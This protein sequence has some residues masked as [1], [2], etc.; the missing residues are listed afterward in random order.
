MSMVEP[1]G[2]FG[3]VYTLTKVYRQTV[4]E[5]VIT[6]APSIDM[7]KLMEEFYDK[8]E[9]LKNLVLKS[10]PD[11]DEKTHLDL[12]IGVGMAGVLLTD[13]LPRGGGVIPESITEE[14]IG[15][16]I[17]SVQDTKQ[18]SAFAIQELFD[19][20]PELFFALTLVAH[21]MEHPL[22]AFLQGGLMLLKIYNHILEGKRLEDQL[23]RFGK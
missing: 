1:K 6:P 8:N 11:L 15:G 19:A 21:K 13:S 10:F 12:R 14:A 7:V 2:E 20:D 17:I 3:S 9:P 22:S 4:R 16:A 18:T 5:L 23:N